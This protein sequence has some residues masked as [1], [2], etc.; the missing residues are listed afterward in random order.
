MK[1]GDKVTIL[2]RTRTLVRPMP[3]IEGGWQISRP[4]DG[5]V[6]WNVDSMKVWRPVSKGLA[7]TAADI[8]GNKTMITLTEHELKKCAELPDVLR[9]LADHHSVQETMADAADYIDSAK[10]HEARYK[11]LRAE[12]DRIQAEWE[13]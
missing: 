9:A 8:R 4:L 5:F 13:K 2:G 12:A 3:N 10:Y 6:F 11:E 7:A 1:P